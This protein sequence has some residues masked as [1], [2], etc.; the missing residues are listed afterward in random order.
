LAALF[1]RHSSPVQL[2]L[3]T[4][5]GTPL[6]LTNLAAN[7]VGPV[8]EVVSNPRARFVLAELVGPKL[9]TPPVV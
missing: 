2:K 1:C 5:S 6:R 8:L 7:A 4:L 9:I 3:I